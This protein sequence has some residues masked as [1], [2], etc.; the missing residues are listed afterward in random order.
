MLR[1]TV[2][3]GQNAT[4]RHLAAAIDSI[5]ADSGAR[6]VFFYVG[7]GYYND[8]RIAGFP[9]GSLLAPKPQ[10]TRYIPISEVIW[11][12]RQRNPALLVTVNDSCSVSPPAESLLGCMPEGEGAGHVRP[13][14]RRLFFETEGLVNINSSSPGEYS[15]AHFGGAKFDSER[16][17]TPFSAAFSMSAYKHADVR[18]D[19]R[20]FSSAL[21]RQTAAAFKN[22]APDG[23][24]TLGPGRVIAQQSQTVQLY[25]DGRLQRF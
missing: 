22:T 18:L 9:C 11:R 2:L 4:R 10:G 8:G 15:L 20:T 17:G 24:L 21:S 23:R 19:W 7:H 16:D 12:I 3:E 1:T 14:A 6:V 25:L 13:L 5:P